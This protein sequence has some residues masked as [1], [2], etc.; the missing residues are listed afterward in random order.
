MTPLI[1][2]AAATNNTANVTT[3]T[4]LSGKGGTCLAEAE[5]EGGACLAEAEGEGG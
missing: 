5:G 4:T 2:K 1:R 3:N